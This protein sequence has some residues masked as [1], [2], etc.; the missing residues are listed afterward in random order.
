MT[1]AMPDQV[2]IIRWHV[3][4]GFEI[5]SDKKQSIPIVSLLER[6][7]YVCGVRIMI[8]YADLNIVLI[9]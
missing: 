6:K 4:L 2:V 8:I 7:T 5:E 1:T 9:G 3:Q